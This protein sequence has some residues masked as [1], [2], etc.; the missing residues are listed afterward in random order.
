MN[1]RPGFSRLLA[2]VLPGTLFILALLSPPLPARA[3]GSF[4]VNTSNDSN[5]IDSE[6]SL[7]EAMAVANGDLTGPFTDA[8]KAR[9]GGCTWSGSSPN[10]TIAGGCGWG[11]G[12][13]I[14]FASS[15]QR[16]DLQGPLPALTDA[17]TTILGLVTT[18]RPIIDGAA[19]GSGHTFTVIGDRVEIAGLTIVNS[20]PTHDD[21][22]IQE[23][24]GA[25]IHGNFIGAV[26]GAADCSTGGVTRYADVGVYVGPL[27]SGIPGTGNGAAYVFNNTI[28]C[29][30]CAGVYVYGADYVYLGPSP[31]GLHTL[32]NFIGSDFYGTRLSN[33]QAGIWLANR[34]DYATIAGNTVS[35]N[36]W[37]GAVAS[38]SGIVIENSQY[39]SVRNNRVGT[40]VSGA[41]ALANGLD[42]I[43]LFGSDAQYNSIGT[44]VLAG[45]N[46]VSGNGRDGIVL[47]GAQGNMIKPN[48]IGLNGAGSG[49]IPNGGAGVAIRNHADST[50]I[51]GEIDPV[52][53]A[54]NMLQGITAADSAH[55][56]VAS[57]AIGV[58]SGTTLAELGNHLEGI[59][60]DSGVTDSTIYPS[61]VANSG[62]AG[63]TTL[64]ANLIVPEIIFDNGSLPIDLGN[65]FRT[66][67]D[68]GDHC[69]G[70]DGWLD[71]PELTTVNGQVIGG[72]ACPGTVVYVYRAIG[73]PAAKGGGGSL[74]GASAPADVSGSWVYTLP[75]PIRPIDVAL[76]AA[77]GAGSPLG[78]SEM[79]PHTQVR[80]P[81]VRR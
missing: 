34:A 29:H 63:I 18:G 74:V 48:L 35:G 23:G 52:Y 66:L 24:T 15:V 44:A 75:A 78:S 55:L 54:G 61:V 4:V 27:A 51:G 9:L 45:M 43:R 67:N 26:A 31:D 17:D 1:R 3:D 40:D 11:V 12:D 47:D 13:L 60:L 57:A 14:T 8:E 36:G 80:L 46:I 70:P 68:A 30:S 21:I 71:Y 10:W 59:Q 6:L 25:I 37:N 58:I 56:Y 28:G 7:R 2:R 65:N 62:N 81:L 33:G 38:G 64:A 50:T 20:A 49:A 73:N 19:I 22:L 53:I 32:G 16:I 79:S 76:L 77:G 5:S 39:A 72:S 42:G 69:L 41:A